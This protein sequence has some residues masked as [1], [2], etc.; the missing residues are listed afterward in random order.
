MMTL[1]SHQAVLK[2]RPS[3]YSQ[4]SKKRQDQS[5]LKTA[6]SDEGYIGFSGGAAG[7]L[8]TSS[9]HSSRDEYDVGECQRLK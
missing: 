3:Y 9:P 4:A 8:Y 7:P 5:S 1:G 2:R 6:S